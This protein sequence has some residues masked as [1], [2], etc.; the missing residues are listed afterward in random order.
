[1][2]EQ[3]PNE[4]Q[5][6]FLKRF[7]R[8][9]FGIELPKELMLVEYQNVIRLCSKSIM[10]LKGKGFPGFV[11]GRI[12]YGRIDIKNEFFQVVGRYATKNVLELNPEQA[13]QFVEAPYVEHVDVPDG[14]Y[15]IKMGMHILGI[16]WVVDHRL[17]TRFVGKGRKRVKNRIRLWPE[18]GD[19]G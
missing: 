14:Y 13:Q 4:S 11:A 1:M 15:V 7:L 18:E 12:R 9:R 19:V 2:M 10:N 6:E 8:E 3:Q 17:Y 16:G 5:V